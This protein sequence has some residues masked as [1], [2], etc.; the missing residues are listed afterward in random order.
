[1]KKLYL[2]LVCASVPLLGMNNGAVGAI[3]KF[4]YGHVAKEIFNEKRELAK[5]TFGRKYLRET[6][7]IFPGILA[8]TLGSIYEIPFV[9]QLGIV[10]FM[11]GWGLFL[12]K[13]YNDLRDG[14]LE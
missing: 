10:S 6:V 11:T 3:K 8:T 9:S 5:G 1:M 12:H 7:L 14:T 13:T 4:S 2:I